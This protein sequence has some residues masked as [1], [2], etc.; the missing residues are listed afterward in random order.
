MKKEEEKTD[1]KQNS[2]YFCASLERAQNIPPKVAA[3][4]SILPPEGDIIGWKKSGRH[5]EFACT[6]DVIVKLKIPASA[7]RTNAT[8]RK[9]RAEF[10]EVRRLGRKPLD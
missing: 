10:A 6:Q 5:S 8:G 7:R 1:K 9:C 2:G 3:Y 4:T